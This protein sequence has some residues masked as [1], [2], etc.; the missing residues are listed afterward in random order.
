MVIAASL[1][2]T[3]RTSQSTEGLKA[4]AKTMKGQT[5]SVSASWFERY[6]WLSLCGI[7]QA[8][9]CFHCTSAHQQHLLTFS[10][11]TEDAFTVTGFRN[12][13]NTLS[14]L[15]AHEESAAHSEAVSKVESLLGP[16]VYTL[17]DDKHKEQQL[18]QQCMLK[19]QLSSLKYL[20][21]SCHSGT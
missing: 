1:A 20:V 3:K 19:K 13:K 6:P 12:W 11:K 8:L 16:S 2:E 5:R 9:F 7:R 4:T 17:L 14:K 18:I 15:A 21:S 10:K